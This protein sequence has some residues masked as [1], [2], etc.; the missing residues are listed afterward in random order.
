[1]PNAKGGGVAG[2]LKELGR[3]GRV[4]EAANP[5]AQRLPREPVRKAEASGVH[6]PALRVLC[7]RHLCCTQPSPGL[8]AAWT[9][10]VRCKGGAESLLPAPTPDYKRSR[11][12]LRFTTS[13]TCS[14]PSSLL[15]WELQSRFRLRWTPN[16]PA[17]LVRDARV[18]CL[19]MPN[20]QTPQRVPLGL[21]RSRFAI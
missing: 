4:K 6:Q 1:M 9:Q 11:Q 8:L 21:R 17:P 15:A 18:L 5:G 16:A 14:T 12:L 7:A 3:P 2:N 13:Y 19:G 10:L 20:S